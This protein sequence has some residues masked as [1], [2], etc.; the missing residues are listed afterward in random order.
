MKFWTY[1]I[2]LDEFKSM[3]THQIV[4]YFNSYNLK[5]F[6]S[7]D[8]EHISKEIKVF[9]GNEYIIKNIFRTQGL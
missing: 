2:N 3:E 1:I 9:I 5:N 7:F 4:L 6:G 8:F